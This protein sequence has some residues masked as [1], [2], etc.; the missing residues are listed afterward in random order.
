MT[1]KTQFLVFVAFVFLLAAPPTQPQA[2]GTASSKDVCKEICLEKEIGD[3]TRLL[4]ADGDRL[5]IGVLLEDITWRDE[6]RRAA[7]DIIQS[8]FANK[9][10]AAP[11]QSLGVVL[12]YIHGTSAV[13]N[14][15]QFVNVRIEILSDQMFLAENAK[16]FLDY[17]VAKITDPTRVVQGELVFAE[18]GVLLA[19][20]EQGM[21]FELW[22]QLN[23][24]KVRETIKKTLSD[25]AGKWDEAGK[26]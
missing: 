24:Q 14:G 3:I 12:L 13:S 16:T 2:G 10:V 15:A 26:K 21:N 25:F 23:L 5:K 20:I 9:F 17:H 4:G 11:D 7:I 19:P 18:N 1:T 22:H 8:Q 6:Y